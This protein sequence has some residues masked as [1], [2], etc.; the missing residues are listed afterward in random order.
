MGSGVG[1]GLFVDSKGEA[2]EAFAVLPPTAT[3]GAASHAPFGHDLDDQGEEKPKEPRLA[4]LLHSCSTAAACQCY[5]A[6]AAAN[7]PP[8]SL[9]N[10]LPQLRVNVPSLPP[11]K[12]PPQ[13]LDDAPPQQVHFNDIPESLGNALPQN[14]FLQSL[15]DSE[16]ELEDNALPQASM[17]PREGDSSRPPSSEFE[18]V[19]SVDSLHS[20]DRNWSSVSEMGTCGMHAHS[21]YLGRI[22][23]RA[24]N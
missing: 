14:A 22:Y 13:S 3:A 1:S 9:D 21:G 16:Y 20:P 8:Q 7:A 10:A 2:P 17:P 5:T 4:L 11:A 19:I 12:A 15:L 24:A 18:L 6:T 23:A